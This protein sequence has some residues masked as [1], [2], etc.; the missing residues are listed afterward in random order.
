MDSSRIR[1]IVNYPFSARKVIRREYCNP[2]ATFLLSIIP[3]TCRRAR[4]V[5]QT[6]PQIGI[7]GTIA[8]P[9]EWS[10]YSS[11]SLPSATTHRSAPVDDRSG[12]GGLLPGEIPRILT[13]C[14]HCEPSPAVPSPLCRL[15]LVILQQAAQS[16]STPHLDCKYD[17]SVS[18][19]EDF[20]GKPFVTDL[21]ESTILNPRNIRRDTWHARL[22]V[23]DEVQDFP[24][25]DPYA[26][27]RRR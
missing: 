15:P 25:G 23:A 21:V 19:G 9:P 26:N 12:A 1:R 18:E 22:G 27:A 6:L 13:I 16:F 10:R 24:V 3:L 8:R 4:H 7:G 5:P 14:A 20:K 2:M 17:C 11:R